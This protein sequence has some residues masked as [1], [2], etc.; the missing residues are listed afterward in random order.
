MRLTVIRCRSGTHE[1]LAMRLFA[2]GLRG[3]QGKCDD[4]MLTLSR[5]AECWRLRLGEV[6]GP[7]NEGAAHW[8]GQQ[9]TSG[10]GPQILV[11]CR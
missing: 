5:V 4:M 7:V 6:V 11:A 10:D 9:D 2:G 8:L 3:G 1:E